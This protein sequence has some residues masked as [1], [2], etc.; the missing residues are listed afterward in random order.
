MQR[1]KGYNKYSAGD[2]SKLIFMLIKSKEVQPIK[3][4]TM[5]KSVIIDDEE[6]SRK[7]LRNLIKDYCDQVEVVD[8]AADL[9]SG[10]ALIKKT[11]PELIFLDIEMP[12][13]TGFEL[14]DKI[15]DTGAEIIFTTAYD[16]YAIQAIHFSALD[17]LLKPINIDELKAAVKKVEVKIMEQV[18]K[19][20]VNYSL[21]VL[22]ENHRAQAENKKIGLPTQS[23]INFVLIKDIVMCK[24][25]GNYSVI[26]LQGKT[27]QEI[28][29]RTLKEFE[30]MLREFNFFRIHR[31]YLINL[32]HIR[33]YSRT[34]QSADY[35]GDGGSV[36]MNNNLHVPVSRDRR[37]HLL[38]RFSKP[39]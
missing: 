13:G 33:E 27:Q 35:D 25:E 8:M 19:Q 20:S 2:Q 6:K 5:I 31:S 11:K 7:L 28:V 3:E 23:G 1:Y 38:E 26:F 36:I 34:N 10:I 9:E 18:E 39:F 32:N 17:Y 4:K 22:L 29:S 15:G 14:L 12:D 24:A 21:K 16:Q 30:D 37:K